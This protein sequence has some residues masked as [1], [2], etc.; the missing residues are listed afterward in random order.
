MKTQISVII[1][2][3]SVFGCSIHPKIKKVKKNNDNF[4]RAANYYAL[5]E[6]AV[7]RKDFIIAERLFKDADSQQPD[8]IYIKEKLLQLLSFLTFYDA[9]YVD[10]IITLGK[11]Y[12]NS[13]LYSAEIQLLQIP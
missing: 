13:K 11:D 5:A 9:K 2:I 12:Y 8:N 4:K 10:E 3:L 1:L 6:A 7:L